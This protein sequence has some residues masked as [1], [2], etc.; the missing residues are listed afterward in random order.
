MIEILF[1]LLLACV[2]YTYA[3]Y[4]VLISLLARFRPRPVAR[5]DTPRPVTMV[6][7]AYNEEEVIAAKIENTLALDYPRELLEIVVV[8]DGSTDQTP[9]IVAAFAGRGIIGYHS[10]TRRGKL[11]AQKRI[12]PRTRHEILVFSDANTYLKP[13]ALRHLVAPFA[14][15]AVGCVAGEKRVV[16]AGGGASGE[17]LY[18][19]YESYLKRMDSRVLSAQ[20]AA[21]E[22]Y[23]VRRSLLDLPPDHI[24]LDD[25]VISMRVA[26]S[27]HRVIYEPE[28][29]AIEADAPSLGDEF[30]R[31]ARNA[32]GG[33]QA[34]WR[35]RGLL[36]PRH[37][38]LWFQFVSHRAM[39][40]AV[41]PL[42]LPLLLL[43]N[44]A[45]VEVEPYRLLLGL[46][47]LFYLLA[48]VGLGLASR[49]LRLR[50]LLVPG[51]FVMMN[52]AALAGL[53]RF[54]RRSQGATW[55]KASRRVSFGVD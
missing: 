6:I 53:V 22:L 17:G 25:F 41:A 7:A 42:A 29:Q 18:W 15:P 36:N 52:A 10:P 4:G 50:L 43:A 32:S 45:L 39:R 9:E 34:M 37:G 1:W 38:L 48:G 13:D 44:V 8:T 11:A 40:W 3:G 33:F 19:R 26:Q 55:K 5:D 14:D 2:V 21:G 24:V 27:G 20:G 51:Y 31:R 47:V 35:L 12:L 54:I 16:G 46:Q 28:A 49:G 30:E 23:A